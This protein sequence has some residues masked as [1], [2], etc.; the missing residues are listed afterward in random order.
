MEILIVRDARRPK[1]RTMRGEQA[2]M[3]DVGVE[4]SMRGE[5][6]GYRSLLQ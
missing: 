5:K 1:P 6:A 3:G 2:E 4:A